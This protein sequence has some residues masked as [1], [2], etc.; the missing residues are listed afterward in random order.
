MRN[1]QVF[2]KDLKETIEQLVKAK[3]IMIPNV[4]WSEIEPY[5][6]T[7]DA[8][9]LITEYYQATLRDKQIFSQQMD[10]LQILL[11][12]MWLQRTLYFLYNNYVVK[13][14]VKNKMQKKDNLEYQDI[15]DIKIK[16]LINEIYTT[17]T[18]TYE[19]LEEDRNE[20]LKKFNEVCAYYLNKYSKQTLIDDI[21]NIQEDFKKALFKQEEEQEK[22]LNE[23]IELDI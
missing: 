1:E 8:R 7:E 9:A 21:H 3:N 16:F 2:K 19:Q 13:G 20:M 14:Y 11:N 22:A 18:D 12:E 15:H 17:K 4:K 10:R 23:A 6:I 5:H